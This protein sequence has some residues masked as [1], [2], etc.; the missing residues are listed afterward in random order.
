MKVL[1]IINIL[2]SAIV[3]VASA[4]ASNYKCGYLPRELTLKRGERQK[5]IFWNDQ[6]YDQPPTTTQSEDNNILET[7]TKDNDYFLEPVANNSDDST[8]NNEEIDIA[9]TQPINENEEFETT[10]TPLLSNE[11]DLENAEL[12]EA[13][14][15]FGTNEEPPDETTKIIDDIDEIADEQSYF[16]DEEIEQ[17]ETTTILV[18]EEADPEE[19][20]PEIDNDEIAYDDPETYF[21]EDFGTPVKDNTEE[22]VDPLDDI[23]DV[24][25]ENAS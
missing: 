14:E 11:E 25:K 2:L 7:T 16:E 1:T 21:N 12:A 17:V 4:P 23:A 22:I 8:S 10:L 6:V 18:E 13:L 5:L 15:E 19:A 9:T 20:F 3:C 24:D